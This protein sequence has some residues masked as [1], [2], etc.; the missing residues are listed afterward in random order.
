MSKLWIFFQSKRILFRIWIPF[1]RCMNFIF[2]VLLSGYQ[3]LY[4]PLRFFR[5]RY[6]VDPLLSEPLLSEVLLSEL[7]L[8]ERI[9][10][11]EACFLM[12]MKIFGYNIEWQLV[13]NVSSNRNIVYPTIKNWKIQVC[14]C[15]SVLKRI[16]IIE[17]NSLIRRSLARIT[18]DN[19]GATVL[20]QGA[21]ITLFSQSQNP[22]ARQT[23]VEM[24]IGLCLYFN[25]LNILE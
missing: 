14:H 25:P 2:W 1:H 20:S 19:G 4:I 16:R 12:Y 15:F 22:T 5:F 9:R 3:E 10:I 13:G 18:S 8:S 24:E 11:M 23:V 7:R 17:L 6:T 21:L